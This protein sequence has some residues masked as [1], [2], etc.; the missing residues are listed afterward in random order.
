M[1]PLES[2]YGRTEFFPWSCSNP[3]Q[4]DSPG[5]VLSQDRMTPLE[6]LTE[7]RMTPLES[8]SP[9]MERLPFSSS[10]P[11]LNDSPG[12]IP[13]QDKMTPLESFHHRTEWSRYIQ[14]QN[15]FP[16]FPWIHSIPGQ[17]YSPGVVSQALND[18]PGVVVSLDRM[19]LL[20]SFHPRTE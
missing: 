4:K 12:V 2:F 13:S 7:D 8:I 16:G 11:G 3:G 14:G 20:D 1:T 15:D 9:G 18:S 19:T 17:K 5:V 6:S 10:I